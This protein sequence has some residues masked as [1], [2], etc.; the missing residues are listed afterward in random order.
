MKKPIEVVRPESVG[1][2][3]KRLARIE[4]HLERRYIA[5]QKI[6]GALTLVARKGKV[7]HLSTVGRWISSGTSRCARIRFFA[8]IR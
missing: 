1:L 6:A 3:S 2:C 8:S 7:A 4:T 5:P